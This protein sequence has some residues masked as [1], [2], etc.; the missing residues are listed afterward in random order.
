ML[1]DYVAYTVRHNIKYQATD[2]FSISVADLNTMVVEQNVELKVGDIL[3]I[4]S[5]Y[6]LWHDNATPEE[7]IE[8]AN[9]IG[10]GGVESTMEAVEWIW[11]H[12]FSAVGGD[13]PA[14]EA[15]PPKGD[16]FLVLISNS[17]DYA[18]S[19]MIISWLCG[20]RR[21]ASCLIAKSWRNCV[22]DMG[23]IHSSSLQ[24]R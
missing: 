18:H 24:H 21:L 2:R 19:S 22:K 14:F 6:V 12:H 13:S 17:Q 20:V 4:R 7:R 1:L 11:N 23:V 8:A 9:K 10:C 3:L 16:I 15:M 5:G